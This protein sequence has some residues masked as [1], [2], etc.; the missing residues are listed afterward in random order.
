[1]APILAAAGFS[2]DI[3]ARHTLAIRSVR[4]ARCALGFVTER[5]RAEANQ[6]TFS[7]RLEAFTTKRT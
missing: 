6:A 3:A 5:H 1:M 4:L 2:F 7:R